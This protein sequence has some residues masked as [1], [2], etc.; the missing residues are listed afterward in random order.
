V[1]RRLALA[2]AGVSVTAVTLFAV[3]LGVA[4]QQAYRDEAL[5]RLQRDTV[6]ATRGIDVAAPGDPVELPDAEELSVYDNR[7][8]R[9]AGR[10]GPASADDIVRRTLRTQKPT[11]RVLDGRLLVAVPLVA[12]E[13]ITGAVRAERGGDEAAKAVRGRLWL[14]LGV[15]IAVVGLAT[16]AAMVFGRQLARPLERL[17]QAARRLGEGDFTVHAPRAGVREVDEVAGALDAAAERLDELISRERAFSTSASHQLRTPLAALRIELEAMEL[18]GDDSAE[19]EAALAQTDRLQTTV[20]TLL[21]VARDIPRGTELTP[22]RGLLYD[23]ESRWRS[24]LA[25][26]GRPLR[27]RLDDPAMAARISASVLREIVDVLLDNAVRHGSGAVEVRGRRVEG[28]VAVDV[29]DEGVRDDLNDQDLF[30]RRSASPSGHGIG[31]PLARSLAR[32]EGGRLVLSGAAPTV[33]TLFLPAAGGGT[34][35]DGESH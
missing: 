4:L 7:G 35:E 30:A 26:R 10:L 13:R 8:R 5:L 19:L 21:A 28:S 2:I 16:L 27:V 20:D 3:P 29:A 11:D 32:A 9:I 12:D 24:P 6:A 31:L 18:R 22:V 14:L 17:A 33:F 1:R 23:A 15:A 25:A 34:Q